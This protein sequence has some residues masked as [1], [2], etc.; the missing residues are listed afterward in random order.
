MP[1]L[2]TS[3]RLGFD[4]ELTI[5]ASTFTGSSQLIGTLTNEPVMI[6]FKNQTNK[7]VFV[8]DNNGSTNGTTMSV[9]EIL[10]LDCRA[11]AGN[12]SNM[13]FP[14]GT[15][16]YITGASGTGNFKITVLYAS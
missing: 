16:F 6:I 2:P 9:N 7:S 11:N 8:A 14:S 3:Q 12:A 5:A 1:N 4:I 15:S 10:L 13:G